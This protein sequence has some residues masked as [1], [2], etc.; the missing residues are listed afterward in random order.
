MTIQ[1]SAC[2]EQDGGG[3]M[4]FSVHQALKL[5]SG[6]RLEGFSVAY[7]TY[8]RLNARRDN[9]I[10]ICHALTV[11]QHVASGHPVTGRPA[12]WRTL[13]GS[14]LP[15]DPDRHFI[16]CSNVIG[17]CM[18]STGPSSTNPATGEP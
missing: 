4:N 12:W 9:A 14:G 10:L 2:A 18:G 1:Q 5:D 11:D 6:G 8:G 17:G 7:K 13:V 15:L 16:I 3:V